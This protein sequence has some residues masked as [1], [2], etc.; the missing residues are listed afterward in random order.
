MRAITTAGERVV[1]DC[2]VPWLTGLLGGSTGGELAEA[3][4]AGET[5]RLTVERS[6]QPFSRDGWTL[7]GRGVWASRSAALL[8]DA[9]S[10]GFDLQVEP[11]GDRLS[12][13]ARYRPSPRTRAANRVLSR[14][15]RLLAAQTLLHYP[16]LWWA[17][18]RGRVPLHVSV[19][20]TG[21]TATMI[22][23]PGG[24]GKSTLLAAGLRRG[25][26]ATADNICA[27]DG[28][29]AH[30]LAEPLRVAGGSGRATTTHG[31]SEH[32]LPS[33][34]PALCPDRI[35]VLRRGTRAAAPY[36]GELS[37]AEAVRTIVAGTYMAGE[38]RRF[39]PF[40][41]ALALATGI[42][43][44]HPDVLGVA[45]ALAARLPCFDVCVAAGSPLPIG[46]LLRPAGAR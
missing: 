8:I 3:S 44:A 39:W 20:S 26:V 41:A 45:S 10:S 40:A 5:V 38:L 43:P 1:V 32:P 13:V 46:D 6:R 34:V 15:F 12:V 24:V 21:G 9:C 14:R 28:V 25:D 11:R 42:G 29:D 36:L 4:P 16:A 33:R 27:C 19:T 22:A 17:S 35:V 30:G 7:I 2:G 18:V 37:P 31:R 23:G